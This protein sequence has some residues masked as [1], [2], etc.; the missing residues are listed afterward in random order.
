MPV[1]AR[2][3]IWTVTLK[4][5]FA[6]WTVRIEAVAVGFEEEGRERERKLWRLVIEDLAGKVFVTWS[7]R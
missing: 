2:V 1:W 7:E 4:I 3:A 5:R 6:C